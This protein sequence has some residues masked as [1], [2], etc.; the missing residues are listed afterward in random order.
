MQKKKRLSLDYQLN[1]SQVQPA[2]KNFEKAVVA[3]AYTGLNRNNSIIEKETFEKALP[4]IKNIPLV[5]NYDISTDTLGGHDLKIVTNANDELEIVNATEPFGVIPES[6][7][8]WWEEREDGKE[9]LMTDVLMW[10]RCPATQHIINKGTVNQS[11]EITVEEGNYEMTEEMRCH[12]KDFEFAALCAIGVEPCFEQASVQLASERAATSFAKQFNL[13]LEDL[14]AFTLNEG[15]ETEMEK[16]TVIDTEVIREIPEEVFEEAIEQEE[17]LEENKET[18]EEVAETEE[19]EVSEEFETAE[20]GESEV[21]FANLYK[22]KLAVLSGLFE[23][24]TERNEQGFVVG[25]TSFRVMEYSDEHLFVSKTVWNDTNWENENLRYSYV[26]NDKEHTAMLTSS[27]VKVYSR[28][29]TNEEIQKLEEEKRTFQAMEE[30]VAR[31]RE[32]KAQTEKD[33]HKEA[34]TEILD[35]FREELSDVEEFISLCENAENMPVQ[36]VENTCY[37]LRGKKTFSRKATKKSVK[38]P[39][40]TDMQAVKSPYGDIFK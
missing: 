15:E 7:K 13:M 10:K 33:A 18:D 26:Y 8:Q 23:D 2:D 21:V 37:M 31:L 22:E 12:I 29:L 28:W 34:V 38:L 40:E 6:A 9:Y 30:E 1:F 5:G 16:E 11:M 4:T 17:V 19:A 20:A 32:F 36:D 14:K 35:M 39:V 3:I 25:G 27:P 24:T